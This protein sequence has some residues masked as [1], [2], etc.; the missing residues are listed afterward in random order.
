MGAEAPPVAIVA[1]RPEPRGPAPRGFGQSLLFPLLDSVPRDPASPGTTAAARPQGGRFLPANGRAVKRSNPAAPN[2]AAVPETT[3][4]H[5]RWEHHGEQLRAPVASGCPAAPLKQF[6]D[7]KRPKGKKTG[8][9]LAVHSDRDER[10]RDRDG[11]AGVS[12]VRQI[13]RASGTGRD[14]PETHTLRRVDDKDASG[15][16]H[17]RESPRPTAPDRHPRPA[18]TAGRECAFVLRR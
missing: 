4:E 8:V 17:S 18:S 3:R 2:P 7:W 12:T 1:T 16:P 9:P 14:R 15:G 13:A 6:R 5:R 10:C 11:T